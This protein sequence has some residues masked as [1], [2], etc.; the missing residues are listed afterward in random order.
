LTK[1]ILVFFLTDD[2]NVGFFKVAI[3]AGGELQDTA[4]YYQAVKL[5]IKRKNSIGIGTD[6]PLSC[7]HAARCCAHSCIF[8]NVDVAYVVVIYVRVIH[9]APTFNVFA[10]DASL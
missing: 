9:A 10:Y 3:E 8:V 2:N 5:T 4:S 7:E 1:Y 6:D